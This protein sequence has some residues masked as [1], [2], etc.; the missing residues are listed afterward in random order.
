MLA[1][2]AP[3][4]HQGRARHYRHDLRRLG[5]GQTDQGRRRHRNRQTHFSTERAHFAAPVY[6]SAPDLVTLVKAVGYSAT[7][8]L[9]SVFVVWSCLHL[10]FSALR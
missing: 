4:G 9:F 6:V 1:T 5:P 2:A 8:T 3:R 7:M 10:C